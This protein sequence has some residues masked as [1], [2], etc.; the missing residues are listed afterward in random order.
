MFGPHDV[1]CVDGERIASDVIDGE[2]IVIDLETGVYYSLDRVGAVVWSLVSNGSTFG[3]IVDRVVERFDVERDR[4][5]GDIQRLVE[6]M[7]AERLVD[8]GGAADGVDE[9]HAPPASREAY[10]APKLE[11]YR[12]LGDLLALDPPAPGMNRIAWSGRGSDEE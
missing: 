11:A 9:L 6:S 4:A 7:A 5:S 3:F 12:D 8:V 1:L 2:A 10:A